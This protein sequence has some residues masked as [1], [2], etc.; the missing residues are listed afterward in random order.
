[1][2]FEYLSPDQINEIHGKPTWKCWKC[3]AEEGLYW[4]GGMSIA[5]CRKP[6][7]DDAINEFFK[8]EIAA[9]DAYNA[10]GYEMYGED[11]YRR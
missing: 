9:E 1:M 5:C 8:A 10:Y 7:C 3:K 6:E 11:W 2:T 4:W